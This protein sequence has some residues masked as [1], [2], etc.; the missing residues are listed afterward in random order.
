MHYT[1][2]E[3]R[4]IDLLSDGLPHTRADVIKCL[5]DH[6]ADFNTLAVHMFN[7]RRK[8][9]PCGQD[10]LLVYRKGGYHYQYV[11]LLSGK[12]PLGYDAIEA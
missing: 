4:I 2:T 11:I 1:P 6:L 3:Q 10:I 7:L 8:V 12:D 9:R 5:K